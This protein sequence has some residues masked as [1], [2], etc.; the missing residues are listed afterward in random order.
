MNYRQ[1][2]YEGYVSHNKKFLN[3][4]MSAGQSERNLANLR[5]AFCRWLKDVPRDGAVLDVG[6]GSGAVLTFLKKEGFTRLHGIELSQEQVALAQERFSEVVCADA[7]EYLPHHKNQFALICAFDLLEHFTKNE[8][9]DFL[10]AARDA[11]VAGGRLLL[12]LP[13]GDSPF[14]GSIAFGDMTH[15]TT[16][17]AV[18][19][20]HLLLTCGFEHIQFQEHGPQSTSLWGCVRW[21]LW[22]MI[23]QVLKCVHRV[24][25]GGVSTG[26]YT[27]V[28]RVT[29]TR[30]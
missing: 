18:S 24:E 22:Q 3:E 17:T 16:Y 23:R 11:L 30:K 1:R 14:V 28:M 25:T 29:A 5:R 2:L 10:E 27:R 20:R 4:A 21:A 15:E 6:C 19:L 12:Q 13:N 9:F 8:A 7:L 26:I